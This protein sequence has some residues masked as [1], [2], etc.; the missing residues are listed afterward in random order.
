[1][2]NGNQLE[3]SRPGTL[4]VEKRLG[5]TIFFPKE[6]RD[7]IPTHSGRVLEFDRVTG[8]TH[9]W[10]TVSVDWFRDQGYKTGPRAQL[11]LLAHETGT[12][13]GQFEIGME[14]DAET[15]RAFGQFLI[16]LA[17]HAER[18]LR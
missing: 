15:M 8:A 4:A 12:L 13:N 17:D 3:L 9:S 10:A 6:L 16:Q 5:N 11:S 2:E 18:P 1:M 14:M 7:A